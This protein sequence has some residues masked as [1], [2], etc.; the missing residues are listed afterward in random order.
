MCDEER[1]LGVEKVRCKSEVKG[2]VFGVW[3]SHLRLRF[4]TDLTTLHLSA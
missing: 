1:E 2:Y 4:M 3:P